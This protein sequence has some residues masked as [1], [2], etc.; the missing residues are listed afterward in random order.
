MSACR[1][2]F[3][4]S[5][6]KYPVSVAARFAASVC[7][8]DVAVFVCGLSETVPDHHFAQTCIPPIVE[9]RVSGSSPCSHTPIIGVGAL[10][11]R[12]KAT[13]PEARAATRR[14][15][16]VEGA[17]S[18]A[19]PAAITE[20]TTL[21]QSTLASP[22]RTSFV[23]TSPSGAQAPVR[24]DVKTPM[25]GTLIDMG[26]GNRR[27]RVIFLMHVA[28]RTPRRDVAES[29]GT[30]WA[31]HFSAWVPVWHWILLSEY[32]YGFTSSDMTGLAPSDDT[33]GS[34]GT[35]L[36]ALNSGTIIPSDTSSCARTVTLC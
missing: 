25:R 22:I 4:R 19:T 7:A 16:V 35:A 8:D 5:R 33:S 15:A 14:K 24:T 17:A 30:A 32:V 18:T 29:L 3:L 36:T 11:P 27:E 23:T 9:A 21:N 28:I 13:P 6:S 10:S 12:T 2:S 31:G 26:I 1:V 20:H 34:E